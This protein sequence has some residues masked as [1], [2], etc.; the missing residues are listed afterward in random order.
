LSK[1]RYVGPEFRA[2]INMGP[3]EKDQALEWLEKACQDRSLS[4][5]NFAPKLDPKFDTLRSDPR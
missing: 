4:N 3:G 5:E 2:L 1:R